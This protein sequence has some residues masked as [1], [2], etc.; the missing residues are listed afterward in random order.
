[1]S[2]HC[3]D[4]D[5]KEAIELSKQPDTVIVD[6]RNPEEVA[7]EHIAS[8][9][10]MPVNQLNKINCE[11]LKNAKTVI[12]HCQGGIRSKQ[13]QAVIEKLSLNN[14]LLLTGGLN[15]WKVSGGK[16]IVNKKA[17]LPIMRQ[18]QMTAGSLVLIG[19]ILGYFISPYFNW[20]SAFIGAGLV[21]SGVTG[22]CGMAGLLMRLPY[23]RHQTKE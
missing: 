20:L 5:A 11:K 16:T 22:T 3:R 14:P 9:I 6:I 12:F 4:I 19:I 1:M 17:A 15:A 13:A 8:A 2:C 7:R 23:N 10:N 21:F 18:V